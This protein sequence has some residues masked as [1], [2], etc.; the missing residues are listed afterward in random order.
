[1]LIGELLVA[2]GLISAADVD[3]ALKLQSQ[4]PGRLGAILIRIGA[5]SEDSLLPAL[6]EQLSI[7]IA[8]ADQL[9]PGRAPILAA[10][11]AGRLPA[12]WLIAQSA[13]VWEAADGGIAC[14][15]RNPEASFLREAV[16]GAFAGKAVTWYFLKSQ[17]LAY[18]HAL[19][20]ASE[21]GYAA[22]DVR[23]LREL[24]EEAPV[25][26]LV[27]STIAQAADERASDIHIE[28]DEA[29]FTIRYR[30]DGVLQTRQVLPRERFDA[31][32]S[33]IKLVSNLDIAERRLPQDGRFSTRAGGLEFDVRVSAIP[34]KHGESIV[35]RLLPK[36]RRDLDLAKLGMQADH[37][38][39]IDRWAQQPNGIVLVTGPTGSGKSTTLYTALKLANDGQ[40]KII[41]V[42]D[43]IEYKMAG[44]VQIQA[45][46]E[47][48]YTFARA[49]RSI[50]RHDPDIIMVGEI[51]DRETAEIAIQAALTGHM[52]FS[53]LHT[54][55]AVASFN[56]LLDMGIEPF[57][58]TSSVRAVV[59]QRLVRQLCAHCSAPHAPEPVF[60][61]WLARARTRWA[62]FLPQQAQWRQA[63]GCGKCNHTGYL[64]RQA[65][66]EIVELTPDLQPL[67]LQRR[68][69]HELAQAAER[70]GMRSMRDDGLI[71]AAHGL[72]T[73]DEVVRV[74]GDE[75]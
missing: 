12:E 58:I 74:V 57:L 72:T 40:R 9:P 15:A 1:M 37:L 53:T 38:A 14:G 31:V 48:G 70:S 8:A 64:G 11:G 17:D 32:A 56:R 52:V 20:T 35:L 33:R 42:E 75:G 69:G 28:P 68:A 6:A 60:I 4:V 62:A 22:D 39:L 41:T 36:E 16:D 54:N 43:P 59:A 18:G 13:L 10:V 55:S 26:E 51:R 5:L 46:T 73:V 23:H 27:N 24:A 66:C 19:L 29:T 7:P 34:A 49:L 47:I 25:I 45:H 61:D 50:L 44:I 2:R 65:I 67:V 71:K 63:V 21:S 30:I 3:R